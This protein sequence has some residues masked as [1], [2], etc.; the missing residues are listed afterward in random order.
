[1]PRWN[2][3]AR[4]GRPLH[5]IDVEAF[6]NSDV[7]AVIQAALREALHCPGEKDISRL[8]RAAQEADR[9][10]QLLSLRRLA[11]GTKKLRMGGGE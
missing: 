9:M 5:Q 2:P 11:L 10:R 6:L 7:L 3:I 4:Q 1:M 8:H